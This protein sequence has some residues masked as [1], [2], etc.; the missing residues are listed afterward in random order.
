MT[1]ATATATAAATAAAAASE[2]TITREGRTFRAPGPGTWEQDPVHFAKP[3]TRAVQELVGEPFARGFARG[4]ALF[5]LLL[6]RF[7]PAPQHGIWYHAAIPFGLEDVPPGAPPPTK[8]QFR[9]LLATSR[10]RE[11]MERGRRNFENRAWRDDLKR[12]DAEVKPR[13]NAAHLALQDV[14]VLALDDEGLVRHL[15]ACASQLAAMW[16]QHHDYT[17]SALLPVGDYLAHASAWTGLGYGELLR[18]LRASSPVSRGAA[19]EELDALVVV[20]GD[21]ASARALLDLAPKAALAALCAQ[22]APLGPAAQAWLRIAGHRSLGYDLADPFALELPEMLVRALKSRLDESASAGESASAVA[23]AAE[24]IRQ[25][26]PAEHRS[27]LDGL[28]AEA[29]FVNRFRDE[30][31]NHSDGWATGLLRR[32]MLEAGRRLA[33]RGRIGEASL[34]IEA[35][36]DELVAMLRGQGG[37]SG[38][39]LEAHREWRTTQDIA[40]FPAFLG[41]APQPPPPA[42]WLPDELQR[43]G[44]AVEAAIAA[45]FLEPEAKV[46]ETTLGGLAVS[47]GTYEGTARLVTDP[48]QFGR[49]RR[50]DVLV[51]RATS[52][53]FNVVLP[54]LGAIVTDRGGQLCHAAIVARESGLP[55]VVGTKLATSLIPDGAR[56]RVDGTTGVVTVL[57]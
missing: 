6:D 24:A 49:L 36:I 44:R 47:P 43:I 8:E 9:A 17:I 33:R 45:L 41:P 30:R 32:A 22:P 25:R 57:S 53:T 40:N 28:L 20:M 50:G 3:I 4:T 39:E 2:I 35:T 29:R 38:E 10:F 54:L 46:T 15:R 13:A 23:R 34:A 27:A 21:D 51:T 1:T 31:G 14:D 16:E 19:A 42:A 55:A 48:S 52:A 11:R 18:P 26:V 7:E 56:I 5:G 37:P 12:W